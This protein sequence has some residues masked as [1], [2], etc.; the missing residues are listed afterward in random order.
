MPTRELKLSFSSDSDYQACQWRYL[1]SH[2]YGLTSEKDKDAL[3][4]GETWHRCHEILEMVPGTKCP[5]CLK[6]E[7]LRP[8]CDLCAGTGYLPEDMMDAVVRHLNRVYGITPDNKTREE[9]ELERTTLL[10]SLSGHRWLYAGDQRFDVVGSEIK[11]VIP[12]IDPA[13]GRKAPKTKF[14]LKVDKLVRDRSS[15]MVYVW[16][17]KSTSQSITDAD[18]WEGLTQGDQVTGYIYGVRVAQYSGQ[19]VR[20]GIHPSDPPVAGA[21][22]DV[23]HK[24]D[25]SPKMLTQADTATF[26]ETG[27]YCGEG[28]TVKPEPSGQRIVVNQEIAQTVPGKKEGAFAIRETPEMFGARLLADIA[29]RPEHYYAQREVSRTDKDLEAFQWHIYNLARQIR[30]VEGKN[31]WVKNVRACKSG[32]HCEFIGLCQSGAEIDPDTVPPGY[33]RKYPTKPEEMEVPIV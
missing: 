20:Y 29:E 10:Y 26:V 5:D 19:L 33:K 27:Q 8:D 28:F 11:C 13:T 31:L 12:V 6:H 21:F 25:I 17:R 9:W 15:G 32:F 4:I 18:Y 16:E 2:I 3:R 23:W 30:H 14:V 22:C 24:P 1:L 7:E